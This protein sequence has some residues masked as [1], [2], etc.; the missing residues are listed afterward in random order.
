MYSS[1]SRSSVSASRSTRC[2]FGPDGKVSTPKRWGVN[3]GVDHQGLAVPAADGM[4]HQ[5]WRHANGMSILIELNDALHRHA[6]GALKAHY[7]GRVIDLDRAE[8]GKSEINGGGN[9]SQGKAPPVPAE[10][11]LA[12]AAAAR[13]ASVTC[14][15]RAITPRPG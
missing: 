15:G 14:M 13:P 10:A 12:S 11:R 4:A 2:L 9:G 8:I 1:C 5:R 6:D 3:P 7:D